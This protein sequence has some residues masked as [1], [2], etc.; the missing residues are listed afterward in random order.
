MMPSVANS[1]APSHLAQTPSVRFSG[2]AI[3]RFR[4]SVSVRQTRSA[5]SALSTP[6]TA[7]T[8]SSVYMCTK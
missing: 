3:R 6:T 7:M 2:M 8:G 5:R 4:S 1:R